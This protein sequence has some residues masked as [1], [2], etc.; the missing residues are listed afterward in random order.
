LQAWKTI[1]SSNGDTFI[2]TASAGLQIRPV[3]NVPQETVLETG[4][5]DEVERFEYLNEEEV[6]SIPY[7]K[8]KQYGSMVEL[9]LNYVY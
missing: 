8:L 3:S 6:I 7:S 9:G 5:G 4:V 2:V 1:T